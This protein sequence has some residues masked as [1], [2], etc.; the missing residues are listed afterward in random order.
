MSGLSQEWSQE[1]YTQRLHYGARPEL[2]GHGLPP[3]AWSSQTSSLSGPHGAS[4]VVILAQVAPGK[5]PLSQAHFCLGPEVPGRKVR[6][7]IKEVHKE[8]EIN[9]RGDD[10]EMLS[11]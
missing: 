5:G 8:C 6:W 9:A 10:L 4:L 2:L 11:D 7:D 3:K 1:C